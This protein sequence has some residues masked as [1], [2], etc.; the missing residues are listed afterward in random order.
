[1]H[2][3]SDIYCTV[4]CSSASESE[5]CS[6]II[7]TEYPQESFRF[8][9]SD[10]I[11]IASSSKLPKQPFLY[12]NRHLTGPLASTCPPVFEVTSGSR[13]LHGF[14]LKFYVTRDI[15][16]STTQRGVGSR[17][18]KKEVDIIA[19]AEDPIIVRERSDIKV[20]LFRT[21]G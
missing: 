18:S 16:G 17:A 6:I 3:N 2:L 11:S 12:H 19:A 4:S 13:S 7:L 15:F 5:I 14:W 8:F 10:L 21:G 20:W 9:S 1:M